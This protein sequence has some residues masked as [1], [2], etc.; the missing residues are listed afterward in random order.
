MS[1][2]RT[3]GPAAS[4]R[5]ENER[6]E[7]GNSRRRDRRVASLGG[8][9]A[10]IVSFGALASVGTASSVEARRL[11]DS[12]LPTVR[13]AASAYVA[14]GASILA[15]MLT[16]ITFSISHDQEFRSTHYRRIRDV[17]VLTTASIVGSV[18]LLIFLSF[19]IDQADVQRSWYLPVYYAVLLGAAVTGGVFISVILM[20]YYAVIGMIDLAEDGSSSDLVV[21]HEGPGLENA[22]QSS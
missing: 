22:D 6:S 11:L 13:F 12:V 20:L 8:L 19:P 9:A 18:L 7:E 17:A 5:S 21:A 4:E 1:S 2:E 10:A 15:L 3:N 14:G 16:L